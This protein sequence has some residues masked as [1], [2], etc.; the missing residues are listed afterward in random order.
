MQML[1][2]YNPLGDIG[3]SLQQGLSSGMELGVN[4]GMMNQGLSAAQQ[5]LTPQPDNPNWKS[6]T[7]AQT[8]F[9]LAKAF[10]GIPGG[11]QMLA[12][13]YPI[14]MQ[15][16]QADTWRNGPTGQQMQQPGSAFGQ[17]VSAAL[18]IGQPQ[19]QGGQQAPTTMQ[20]PAQPRQIQPQFN[21]SQPK[22]QRPIQPNPRTGQANISA[23]WSLNNASNGSYE[24]YESDVAKWS[25]LMGLKEAQGMAEAKQQARHQAQATEIEAK[26]AE[27]GLK[28]AGYVNETDRNAFL[29]ERLQQKGL[30]EKGQQ[31][32][33]TAPD[34]FITNAAQKIFA[35]ESLDTNKSLEDAWQSTRNKVIDLEESKSNLAQDIR[36]RPW[37]QMLSPAAYSE[38]FNTTQRQARDFLVKSGGYNPKNGEYDLQT[39]GEARNILANEEWTPHEQ[40]ELTTPTSPSAKKWVESLS[41]LPFSNYREYLKEENGMGGF[42][43][44]VNRF[45]QAERKEAPGLSSEFVEAQYES[46]YGKMAKGLMES[47]NPWDS[48]LAIKAKVMNRGFSDKDFSSILNKAR[49]MGMILSEYQ[50]KELSQ[51]EAP[52]YPGFQ[53]IWNGRS[54]FDLIKG[55]AL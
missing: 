2:R 20:A 5:L 21:P 7:A 46:Q 3:T 6:P 47:I 49:E 10:A 22:P 40:R 41:P 50:E 8:Y 17:G 43:K 30:L 51:V 44:S 27:L 34:D 48:L 9:A 14:I 35:K 28:K 37:G 13:T 33:V 53:D 16:L 4:R 38:D 24:E 25:P 15:Q 26:T 36:P 54:I 31:G 39:L 18:G 42:Y 19:T 29:Q 1:P 52:L 23:P 32:Q 55:S 45:F 11:M 12:E